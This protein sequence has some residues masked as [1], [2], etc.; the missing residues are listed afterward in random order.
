MSSKLQEI[1]KKYHK[2][3][4]SISFNEDELDYSVLEDHRPYL[5]HLD[6]IGK[7]A[8]SVFD[9]NRKTHVYFSPLYRERLGL[10]DDK[11]EGPEGFDQL[12]H[13]ED[14]LTAMESGY[15]FLKMAMNTDT[16]HLKD[17]KLVNDY[18]IQIPDENSIRMKEEYQILETDP[19]G[20][21]WL[22]LSIVDV[23][24]NQNLKE[25]MSSRL[26]NHKT[27]EIISFAEVSAFFE[28]TNREKEIL[29][30]ISDGK[31]SKE[32][33]DQLHI[34]VHTVNTHRQNIIEKMDVTNTAE[35]IRL[36]SR[37]GI[38]G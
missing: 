21:I 13:P 34:S 11:H 9:M 1:Q 27:G 26:V 35:A 28:L 19:S 3:L 30:F 2:L 5:E 24:P 10:P 8:I 38:L 4:K 22:S 20:N 7:S 32:I 36:A 15:H 29:H 23:S 33:A 31:V 25:P 37:M 17:F 14:L 18:R 6:K 16:A 12:M